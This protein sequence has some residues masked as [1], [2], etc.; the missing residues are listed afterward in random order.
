MLA[1]GDAIPTFEDNVEATAAWDGPLFDIWLHYRPLIEESLGPHGEA[2]LA[3]HPPPA[4]G[5]CLDIGCGLGD[6]TFRMAELVGP[7]GR[8]HGVDVA[9]RMIE[10]AQQDLERAGTPNVSFAV[11]DVESDDLG[12]TYDYAFGRCGTM[13]FANPVPAFRNVRSQL[14]PG[15]LLNIVVWRHKLDNDWLHKA[16]LI[17]K[18]Y[19]DKPDETDEP[20]CGPG[21][22]AM[23][24]ADTVSDMVKFGGYE[25][26]RLARCDLP[27]KMGDDLDQAVVFNM[28]IGPAAEVLRLWGDRVDDIRPTIEAELYEGLEEFVTE[29]GSVVGPSSTWIVTGRAPV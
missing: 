11:A 2:A 6:T 29:D 3:L 1:V 9:P 23:A 12:G 27:Y 14:A 18:K 20:T 26:I 7:E 13:F 8:S 22:F 19:L 25:D 28:A 21:P 4:G 5:Q 10:V 24:N 16:E 15:G 17:V